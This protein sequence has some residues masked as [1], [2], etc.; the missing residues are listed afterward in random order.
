MTDTAVETVDRRFSGR[1]R[2]GKRHG[3]WTMEGTRVLEL[4]TCYYKHGKLS[5]RYAEYY[6]TPEETLKTDGYYKNGNRH[7]RWKFHMIP[8]FV[9]YDEG[10]KIKDTSECSDFAC[11]L[12]G[13]TLGTLCAFTLYTLGEALVEHKVPALIL[14]Y[15]A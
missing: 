5:G 15:V 9:Q 13:T 3:K 4:A 8:G 2:N 12:L 6:D 14:S 10:V 1:F 11:I 7:G